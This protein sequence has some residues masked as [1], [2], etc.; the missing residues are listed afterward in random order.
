MSPE[1]VTETQQ[2]LDVQKSLPPTFDPQLSIGLESWKARHTA[3]LDSRLEDWRIRHAE[4]NAKETRALFSEDE[5]AEKVPSF[6]PYEG[7]VFRAATP[8]ELANTMSFEE[9]AAFFAANK[10]RATLFDQYVTYQA[11]RF[12]KG[13]MGSM[14]IEDT[15]SRKGFDVWK[16]Q[17][18]SV[19]AEI[20]GVATEI[21]GFTLSAPGRI[22]GLAVGAGIKA[23]P[24]STP[25]LR[26]LFRTALRPVGSK[27]LKGAAKIAAARGILG[28]TLAELHTG[29]TDVF[30][31][32]KGDEGRRPID[33]VYAPLIGLGI[34][35][36]SVPATKLWAKAQ[37]FGRFR[38]IPA[39]KVAEASVKFGK[40]LRTLI[41][42]RPYLRK[43]AQDYF[44]GGKRRSTEAEM[45]EFLNAMRFEAR[46]VTPVTP[47]ARITEGVVPGKEAQVAVVA[48]GKPPVAPPTAAVPTAPTAP[49]APVVAPEAAAAPAPIEAQISAHESD[50]LRAAQVLPDGGLVLLRIQ[51]WASDRQL[52]DDQ[53]RDLLADIVAGRSLDKWTKTAPLPPEIDRLEPTIEPTTP[54]EQPVPA[55][56]APAAEA[57]AEA[58]PPA[59]IEYPAAGELVD[60]RT[61]ADGVPE[62]AT[63]DAV[64]DDYAELPGI[65]EIPMDA[66]DLTQQTLS[67]AEKSQIPRLVEEIRE[68]NEIS[69]LIVVQD[70]D[71]LYILEGGHRAEALSSLGAKSFPA[72]VVQDLSSLASITPTQPLSQEVPTDAS[73]RAKTRILDL[74]RWYKGQAVDVTPSKLLYYALTHEA[75]GAR[76]GYRAGQLDLNARH[77]EMVDFAK[78]NL[79][80]H[81]LKLVLRAME[82][83]SKSRTPAQMKAVIRSINL[84]AQSYE[85]SAAVKEFKEAMAVAKEKGLLPEFQE[86]IDAITED[87]SVVK[88]TARIRRRFES[89]VAAA[90]KD[91][92]NE[93][94]Q[95]LVDKA[96]EALAKATKPLLR[97]MPP[98]DVRAI[99]QAIQ[100][101]AAQSAQKKFFINK[102]KH[103]EIKKA[104]NESAAEVTALHPTKPTGAPG[105]FSEA[106][107]PQMPVLKAATWDQLSLDLNTEIVFGETGTGR[108]I[109]HDAIKTSHRDFLRLIQQAEDMVAQ[110]IAEQG[111]TPEML[112]S[113]SA[114]YNKSTSIIKEGL[115]KI[116]VL[117]VAKVLTVDT[118]GATTRAGVPVPT[119]QMTTAE[120]MEMYNFFQDPQNRAAAIRN[121]QDG[122]LYDRDPSAEPIKM[123][124]HDVANIEAK[125]RENPQALALANTL[126]EIVNG[127]LRDDVNITSMA[128]FLIEIWPRTNSWSRRR[129]Q[130]F[131]HKDPNKAIEH[132]KQLMFENMG[133]F[134]ERTGGTEPFMISDIFNT[135]YAH[136]SK[137]AGYAHKTRALHDA[138][139]LLDQRDMKQAI[140]HGFKHGDDRI[141]DMKKAIIRY[142]GRGV[143][144]QSGFTSFFNR[145]IQKA[146]QALIG[147]KLHIVAFQPITFINALNEIEAKWLFPAISFSPTTI[148]ET[149]QEMSE[150]SPPLRARIDSSGAQILNPTITS[151]AM[152]QHFGKPRSLLLRGT[153]GPI[154]AADTVTVG[155]IWRAVKAKTAATMGLTGQDL[156]DATALLTE[157]IVD[158]TQPT[159]DATTISTLA[160]NARDDP[161]F[162][163]FG[164]MFSSVRNKNMHQMVRGTL[165]F[166]RAGAKPGGRTRADWERLIKAW[167]IPSIVNALAVIAITQGKKS[168]IKWFWRLLGVGKYEPEKDATDTWLDLAQLMMDKMWGNVLIFG[169]LFS[170]ATRAAIRGWMQEPKNLSPRTNVLT[171][172]GIK[173]MDSITNIS[174]GISKR[175]ELETEEG[176]R[177]IIRGIDEA[178]SVISIGA[179]IPYDGLTEFVEPKLKEL[180]TKPE[181]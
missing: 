169:D 11:Q 124:I 97:D 104:T 8:Q 139:R 64:L 102:G 40:D 148:S 75:R 163:I 98:E 95:K 78:K 57:P 168:A 61:V 29:A 68:S 13:L 173:A 88:R 82:R 143:I 60:G 25:R 93:I 105:E 122:F 53:Y 113:W 18:K 54:Q 89:I 79:P 123:T 177:L 130:E 114:A 159:W 120:L 110:T 70:A 151:P 136:L 23:I 166:K 50:I 118:P 32:I 181:N 52:P 144:K 150:N 162:K 56:A 108:E 142:A 138:L 94:P 109:T 146:Q 156:L 26:L 119:I 48:P 137:A 66:I 77:Q 175:R 164:L 19:P 153:L 71:G 87:F 6:K 160:A 165:R 116:R 127:P 125:M 140:R 24:K 73:A 147:G 46:P 92:L 149:R 55:P 83:I 121:K 179:G 34:G 133:I 161:W 172:T 45:T 44:V 90:G 170:G 171:S 4:T 111:I 167:T 107:S 152:Q 3:G 20:L 49:K 126:F 157:D 22:A 81:E 80:D 15:L 51:S 180:T 27:K 36:M 7:P 86:Q 84:L 158:R 2:L 72:L 155:T 35:V 59:I 65:R 58:A 96:R 41:E 12:G 134:L 16:R 132:H 69:P 141:R 42:E 38:D 47:T 10:P 21:F 39:S 112:S 99:T 101:L 115:K 178:L 5:L 43:A 117:G 103:R 33:Y 74:G 31:R 91:K 63:I 145:V 76:I 128:E 30:A 106:S 135:Y 14:N 100:A 17:T 62:R 37:R 1:A 85:R 28:A 9:E 129:S 131:V 176:N 154:H 174:R 67:V